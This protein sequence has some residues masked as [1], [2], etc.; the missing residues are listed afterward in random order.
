MH[1]SPSS[2][3]R[4]MWRMKV[5]GTRMASLPVE[6][7]AM[8]SRPRTGCLDMENRRR[9][10][11]VDGRG[12]TMREAANANDTPTREAAASTTVDEAVEFP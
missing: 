3:Q 1:R 10:A 4:D 7:A 5:R 11:A 9:H 12:R 2:I 6:D 8:C